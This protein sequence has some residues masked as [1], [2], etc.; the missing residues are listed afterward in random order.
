VDGLAGIGNSIL[1]WQ[2][3]E[4]SNGR[5]AIVAAGQPDVSSWMSIGSCE[6]WTRVVI[7]VVHSRSRCYR[8]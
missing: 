1:E 6:D 3:L 5:E 7:Q 4:A 2:S 8:E